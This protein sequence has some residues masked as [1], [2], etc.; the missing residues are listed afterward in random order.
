[1]QLL[2]N[3]I[4]TVFATLVEPFWIL[5]NRLLCTLQPFKDLAAGKTKP[6]RS[7]DATYTSIPPQLVF[8]RALKSKHFTLLVVCSIALLANLLAVGLGALFNEKQMTAKYTEVFK[9]RFTAEFSNSSVYN[10]GTYLSQLLKTSAQYQDHMHIASANITAGTS[11]PPWV[12][13]EYFFQPHDL[14][15]PD[16]G[17]TTD[18]YILPIRGFGAR[19][20]CTALPSSQVPFNITSD[21]VEINEDG[22][23]DSVEF[24]KARIREKDTL[25]PPSGPSAIEYSS[26]LSPFFPEKSC[27]RSIILAWGRANRMLDQNSTIDASFAFCEPRFETAMFNVTVDSSGYVLAYSRTTELES[28]LGY[29]ESEDQANEILLRANSHMVSDSQNFHNDT[30]TYDWLSYLL[31]ISSGSRDSVDPNAPLP[32]PRDMLAPMEDIYHRLFAAMLS[33]NTHLF[34]NA[35]AEESLM[36]TRT[37]LETRIFMDTPSFIIS[38]TVLGLNLAVALL[39]YARVAVFILPRMPTTIGS[40]LAYVAPSRIVNAEPPPGGQSRTLSFGR[41]LG[42]DGETHLGIELDPHVVP[43][44]PSSLREKKSFLARLPLGALRRRNEPHRHGTWL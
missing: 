17:T 29:P 36:G 41:Y 34:N 21:E 28:T 8:F 43:I 2:E 33:L 27:F 40:I 9:P 42:S 6:K 15:E 14:A 22:C 19:A 23:V 26:T 38:M 12:S 39:F 1:M 11:L 32:N 30:L 37:T 31:V 13:K 10:F 25:I 24:A 44:D 5:L 18:T 20:N 16:R 4:P 7:V 35:T 3:Y